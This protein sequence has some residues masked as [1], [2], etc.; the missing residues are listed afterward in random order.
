MINAL[1]SNRRPLC[2]APRSYVVLAAFIIV[3][4][5]LALPLF[6]GSAS[7]PTTPVNKSAVTHKLDN[8]TWSSHKNVVNPILNFQT[9]PAGLSNVTVATFAGNCNDAKTTFNLQDTDLTVCAKFT[10][11]SPGWFVI[12]SNAR[13][14]AVQMSPITAANSS[15]TF[16]L[17][18][19]SN[20]G[21]WRVII[22][23]PFGNASFAVSP[24]T[25]VDAANPKADL[26]VTTSV[27]GDASAN[28]QVL[29]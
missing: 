26:A 25:V 27:L 12:W 14:T 23:E 22:Y 17:N 5:L 28:S 1:P 7:A 3:G 29:F 16:T 24:F 21:D 13:G 10:N 4:A 20:L 8:S 9:P 6:V 11:A 15:A 18:A 2:I 19:N